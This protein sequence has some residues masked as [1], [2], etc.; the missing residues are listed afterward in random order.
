MNLSSTKRFTFMVNTIIM[1]MVLAL[2]G[3]FKLIEVNFLVYFSIPTLMVYI[4]GYYLIHKEKLEFY[5][6]MV[7]SWITLYM[8]VCTVCLGY[9]YGF[10]LYCF[11]VIPTIFVTEYIAYK[12]NKKPL[13]SVRYCIVIAVFYVICTGYVALNGP[14]YERSRKISAFFWGINAIIVFGFLIG[15]LT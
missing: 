14:I 5:T 7:Y 6:R 9:S 13:K 2:M 4:L 10:H 12:L 1:L 15:Y 3:F 11:S 8:G